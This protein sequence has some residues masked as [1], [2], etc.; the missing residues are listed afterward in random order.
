MILLDKAQPSGRRGGSKRTAGTGP[1][2]EKLPRES[3]NTER[4]C[5]CEEKK[6]NEGQSGNATCE[7]TVGKCR[8]EL[9]ANALKQEQLPK[10]RVTRGV[11]IRPD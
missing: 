8:S 6:Q 1:S 10:T 2:R 7:T 9:W 5:K 11:E 3:N 4:N